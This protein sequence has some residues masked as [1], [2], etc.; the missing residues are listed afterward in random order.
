MLCILIQTS[1]FG[2]N[3]RHFNNIFR[4]M[5][6]FC[7]SAQIF[8][9]S[10]FILPSQ[11]NL[12]FT[13]YQIY[14]VLTLKRTLNGI[15]PNN[16]N[17]YVFA[18]VT[19]HSAKNGLKFMYKEYFNLNFFFQLFQNNQMVLIVD[20]CYS[21]RIINGYQSKYNKHLYISSAKKNEESYAAQMD[22]FGIYQSTWLVQELMALKGNVTEFVGKWSGQIAVRGNV[23]IA[24]QFFSE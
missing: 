19:G 23:E 7:V 8:V 20:S 11:S 15:R 24:R 10:P 2:H 12:S 5:N 18:Y 9:F 13:Q 3:Q 21:E 1:I 22:E 16:A 6:Q 14:S 17:E 4:V